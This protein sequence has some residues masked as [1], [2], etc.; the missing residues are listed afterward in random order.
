MNGAFATGTH[1][2]E[3]PCA[4]PPTTADTAAVVLQ[5]LDHGASPEPDRLAEWH[6]QQQIDST[7]SWLVNLRGSLPKSPRNPP[8]GHHRPRPPLRTPSVV[9]KPGKRG[10]PGAGSEHD[11][12]R[13]PARTHPAVDLS[14]AE[15]AVFRQR[16]LEAD[17]IATIAFRRP[18]LSPE[19]RHQI[20]YWGTRF[21]AARDPESVVAV[22]VANIEAALRGVYSVGNFLNQRLR[23]SLFSLTSEYLDSRDCEI[24]AAG[25]SIESL[26]VFELEYPNLFF[27]N[28][29][30]WRADRVL[31]VRHPSFRHALFDICCSTADADQR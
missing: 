12:V 10:R 13:I 4:A 8:C 11:S 15:L 25:H 31:P 29:C 2:R 19:L 18:C 28:D 22:H 23:E 9:A 24:A 30:T 27:I 16:Q 1:H 3:P 26:R 20:Q 21:T 14:P 17:V 6:Q 5:P 7:T